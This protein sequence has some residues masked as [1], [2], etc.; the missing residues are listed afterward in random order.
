MVA[1]NLVPY[2]PF[3]WSL[4]PSGNY[5]SASLQRW[6]IQMIGEVVLC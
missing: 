5:F 4:F 3:P 6:L 2:E 1:G